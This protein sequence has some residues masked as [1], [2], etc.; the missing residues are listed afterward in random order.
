M[1]R[2]KRSYTVGFGREV[3]G[4]V[5]VRRKTM[6]EFEHDVGA[7]VRPTVSGLGAPPLG[8][9]RGSVRARTGALRVGIRYLMTVDVIENGTGGRYVRSLLLALWLSAP[10]AAAADVVVAAPAVKG[11]LSKSDVAEGHGRAG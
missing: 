11:A 1:P 4:L 3:V 6:P 8:L 7:A 5:C 2:Q 9:D 10:A